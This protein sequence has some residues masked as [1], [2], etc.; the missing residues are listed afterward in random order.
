M[1]AEFKSF[2][3]TVSGN[4]GALC[5]Y[6]TRLDT[7]GCGC[8]HNCSYCYARS[9]LEFRNLWHPASPR[10]A[11]IDKIARRIKRIEPGS[12]I[13]LGGMTDCLQPIEAQHKVTRATIA[14]LNRAGIGYLIVTKSHLIATEDYLGLLDPKLA[15][16]QIT[17]TNTDDKAALAYEKCSLSSKRLDAAT[18]LQ[19]AGM[20]VAL[21]LSPYVPEFIDP[22]VIAKTGVKKIVV[23]FLR[24]NHWIETW[25]DGLVDLTPYTLKHGGYRHLPLEEKV[26]RLAALREAL[27]D[28]EFTV[29]EDVPEHW[30]Y[31]RDHV[32]ANPAD[33]CNLRRS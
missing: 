30:A 27:P 19:D 2:F 15:H 29:C 12:I 7:Y 13:R 16:I 9:L 11:S 24:V 17:V 3:K 4:E 23:E 18:K 21:R 1:T 25:V 31:W 32:N 26:R 28:C 8:E 33:C 10:V 20:D 14:M 5:H 6:T 22:G